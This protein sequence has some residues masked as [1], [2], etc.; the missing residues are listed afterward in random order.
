M[1]EFILKIIAIFFPFISFLQ[2]QQWYLII[3]AIE[4]AFENHCGTLLN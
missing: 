4:K 3:T 1:L 2:I